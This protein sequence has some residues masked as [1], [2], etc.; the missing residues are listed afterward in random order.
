MLLRRLKGRWRCLLKQNEADTAKM[1]GV[2]STFCVLHN[3]CESFSEEFDPDLLNEVENAIQ[4]CVQGEANQNNIGNNAENIRNALV[5][6]CHET[7][8]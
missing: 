3:I 8:I 2:I 6:Y 5:R 7:N 4:P 1:N